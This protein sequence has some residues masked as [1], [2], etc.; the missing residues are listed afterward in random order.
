MS[1]REL[2][3]E[4]HGDNGAAM[5]TFWSEERARSELGEAEEGCVLPWRSCSHTDLMRGPDDSVWMTDGVSH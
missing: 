2:I 1:M 5:S 3:E 4:T